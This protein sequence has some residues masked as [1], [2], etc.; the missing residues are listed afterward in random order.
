MIINGEE[1]TD[2]QITAEVQK[3]KD[4][5]KKTQALADERRQVEADKQATEGLNNFLKF[6]YEQ[7][8]DV[9]KEIDALVDRELKKLN[10]EPLDISSDDDEPSKIDVKK[11]KE[12]LR[13]EMAQE[14][15]QKIKNE[16]SKKET[17]SLVRNELEALRKSGYT[18]EELVKVANYAKSRNIY[19]PKDAIGGMILNDMIPNRVGKKTELPPVNV[20]SGKSGAGLGFDDINKELDK[21]GGDPRELLKANFDKLIS[22]D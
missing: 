11:L 19:S 13:R 7:N 21:Y 18:D 4:Y 10:G 17:E 12:E 16:L 14:T 6:A 5:T 2:E 8:P 3:A 22:K 1:Y 15:E 9:G 20:M